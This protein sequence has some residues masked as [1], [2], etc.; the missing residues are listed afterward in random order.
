M[1]PN[2]IYFGLIAVLIMGTLGATLILCGHTDILLG[3]YRPGKRKTKIRTSAAISQVNLGLR[4]NF[5]GRGAIPQQMF[6]LSLYTTHIY[7]MYMHACVHTYTPAHTHTHRATQT[8]THTHTHTHA[9]I[10][11]CMHASMH[12]H[13]ITH[14][15]MHTCIHPSIRVTIFGL[16][17]ISF[18]A[19]LSF[20]CKRPG[21]TVVE[22][23]YR[24]WK[25]RR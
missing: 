16:L 19:G 20:S 8:Q 5:G 6:L 15:C 21:F 4:S 13:I 10:H 2:S 9:H 14:A 24:T 25:Y 17:R 22:L 18:C 12:A 7:R 1:Y 23:V 11:T 3:R